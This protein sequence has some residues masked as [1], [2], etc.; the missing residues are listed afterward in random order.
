MAGKQSAQKNSVPGRLRKAAQPP[1]DNSLWDQY[2]EQFNRSRKSAIRWLA[3][4]TG[5]RYLIRGNYGASVGVNTGTPISGGVEGGE[6]N[7]QILDAKTKI[8]YL[9]EMRGGGVN[10]GA[11]LNLAK[12]IDAGGST[13]DHSSGG[14]WVYPNPLYRNSSNV[15]LKSYDY[16]IAWVAGATAGVPIPGDTRIK[17][18][19]SPGSNNFT[20]MHMLFYRSL[21]DLAIDAMM[22]QVPPYKFLAYGTTGGMGM[23]AGLLGIKLGFNAFRCRTLLDRSGAKDFKVKPASPYAPAVA[24]RQK[25][26]AT[27]IVKSGM[28]LSGLCSKV[29][30]SS[31]PATIRM[32]AKA[33][34]IV[35]PS[36]IQIGQTIHFPRR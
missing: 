16:C 5:A 30:G 13:P 8:R 21:Q 10:L 20:V 32:V 3:R 2:L 23:D 22:P 6:V 15:P 1:E 9:L 11:G 18:G 17:K 35:N 34:G 24:D 33:N 26:K 29:Y 28:T 7:L 25:Y 19:E 12:F 27:V 4:K 14:S 36:R 31:R